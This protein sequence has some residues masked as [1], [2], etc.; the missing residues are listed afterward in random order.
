[1]KMLNKFSLQQNSFFLK[2]SD[3]V[4]SGASPMLLAFSKHI[5]IHILRFFTMFRITTLAIL[6]SV[7]SLTC[8]AQQPV[9]YTLDEVITIAQKQSPDALKAKHS[10]RH[11]YW[12]YR[13]FKATYLPNLKL[14]ATMPNINRTIAAVPSQDGSIN[15]TPQSLTSYSVNLSLNQEIGFTGGQVSLNTGL[16]RMDN[17]YTDTTTSQFLANM[18]NVSIRQPIF[19]Y[20][21]YK[22]LKKIE[23]M[24][25]EAAKRVVV[26]QNEKIASTA[27]DHF[28]S[29][30]IAQLDRQIA[31][32][33]QSNYDTLYNIAM[34]RYTLG[35]IAENELLQLELNLLKATAE[36]ENS[37]LKYE[38][39]FFTFKS[40][41]RIKDDVPV[42]LIPPA[43]TPD[44]AISPEKAIAEAIVNS[45]DGLN[46][47]RRLLEAE[48]DV[49]RAK[50]QGRFDAE[51]YAVLGLTQTS[52]AF[53]SA[54]LNPLDEER[55]ILGITVPILDWGR[56]KGNIKMAESNEDLVKTAVE[57]EIIDFKQNVFIRVM[58]Y[59]M[60]KNQMFIA[61][62]SDTV[63]QKRFEIT[64]K[65]YMIG[66]I[67]DVLELRMAQLDND[68]ARVGYYRALN[69]YWKS[70]YEIRRLTLYDF[71]RDR[72]ISL[73]IDDLIE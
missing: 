46:F 44:F 18:I 2:K 16:S 48:S 53:S 6:F 56:A 52:D 13:F 57:Q 9:K 10:F 28:F 40:Y 68:N 1:M 67:N 14:D 22:W 50:M 64:Q 70:Y 36:L 62:K 3:R 60:Q 69:S 71:H 45:S 17:Y 63:A 35:K 47:K 61:A 41:L 26:E 59:N 73:G 24:K 7:I 30:L 32:K 39:S 8:S 15:Y 51:L 54:Y 42:E 19:N 27:V 33:N 4:S 21:P 58:E 34:G 25:Y 11:S 43:I 20:N 5:A 38:N 31:Y 65:R 29:L 72:Q 66:K 37:E 23:P 12:S 55:I 49:N